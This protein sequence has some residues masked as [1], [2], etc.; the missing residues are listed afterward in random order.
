M[1]TQNATPKYSILPAMFKANI[2]NLA[3]TEES[4]S[5]AVNRG[6]REAAAVHAVNDAKRKERGQDDWEFELSQLEA[7]FGSCGTVGDAERLAAGKNQE[8]DAAVAELE[9]ALTQA[10]VALSEGHNQFT[11]GTIEKKIPK[12]EHALNNARRAQE[13]SRKLGE[14]SIRS[15]T[16]FERSDYPRLLELRKRERERRELTER[17]KN[18]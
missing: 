16:E 9:R 3:Y 14:Q 6:I 7:R 5:E 10:R 17:L 1:R 13:I 2:Q 18:L 11:R 4:L 12:L 15:A 8:R